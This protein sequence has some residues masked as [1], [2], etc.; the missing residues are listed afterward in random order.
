VEATGPGGRLSVRTRRGYW[1]MN[2][3]SGIQ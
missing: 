3:P 2:T 1:A